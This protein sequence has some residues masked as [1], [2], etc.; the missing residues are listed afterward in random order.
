MSWP[1]ITVLIITYDRPKE[2]REVIRA[3]QENLS[4]PG[5]LQWHLADDS[6][7]DTYALDILGDFP[8]LSFTHTVTPGRS[9]WGINV[10]TGLRAI[11]T[12]YVFQ[13]EDDQVAQRPL[14]LERGVYV[15]EHVPAVGLVRYDGLEGHRLVL[16]TDE[17]PKLD[18]Y[19]VHFLRIDKA[20]TL[21]R[22]TTHGYSNRPHLKCRAFHE[23]LGYYPEGLNLGSTETMYAHH[24]MWNKGPPELVAL[25]DGV[26]RA[27][28]HIGK[29]RQLTEEDVGENVTW[30][31][32]ERPAT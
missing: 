27:F 20:S 1:T 9:G 12:P 28:K 24:V 2:V 11:D 21:K 14:D 29:S 8:D 4:Y 13:C 16:Y 15:M 30:D 32:H 26:V 5:E 23:F 31:S 3:L 19:R 17:T 22:K 6:S 7:P 25:S 18:G 10:N